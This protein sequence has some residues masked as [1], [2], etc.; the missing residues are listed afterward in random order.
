MWRPRPPASQAFR[1]SSTCRELVC[2]GLA[3]GCHAPALFPGLWRGRSCTPNPHTSPP[4]APAGQAPGAPRGGSAGPIPP[5]VRPPP[6]TQV[7]PPQHR[8]RPA[9]L[10][11]L[12]RARGLG[13][14]HEEATQAEAQP[15]PHRAQHLPEPRPQS[16]LPPEAPPPSPLAQPLPPLLPLVRRVVARVTVAPPPP[17]REPAADAQPT[18]PHRPGLFKFYFILIFRDKTNN[19][20]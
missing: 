17:G 3:P 4:S 12:H 11:R 6:L 19:N 8:V 5:P 10:Q 15:P 18:D 1:A 16:P 2:P 9:L 13:P 14:P 20:K 7:L